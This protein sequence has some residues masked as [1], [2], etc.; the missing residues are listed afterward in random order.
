[1]KLTNKLDFNLTIKR[2]KM[3]GAPTSKFRSVTFIIAV[4]PLL[5]FLV[6][7]SCLD[8]FDGHPMEIYTND[9]TITPINENASARG[10]YWINWV[11][12]DG[13]PYSGEQTWLYRINDQVARK[14]YYEDGKQTL[15]EIFNQDEELVFVGLS[16][17]TEDENGVRYLKHFQKIDSS[18][19]YLEF[20]ATWDQNIRTVKEFFQSGQLK[21]EFSFNTE[22]N[23]YEGFAF[24]YDEQGNLLKHERYENGI[25]IETIK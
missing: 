11:D 24:L 20:D 6:L 19:Q 8:V 17:F 16:E 18:D 15:V 7:A 4:I 22:I 23:K 25:L 1:M 14:E 10:F 9:V 2:F 21:Y 5:G 12:S 13:K 3:M